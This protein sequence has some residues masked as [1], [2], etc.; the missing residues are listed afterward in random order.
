MFES[1]WERAVQCNR[2]TYKYCAL[3]MVVR[4]GINKK[5]TK[6]GFEAHEMET[7]ET[8]VSGS[9]RWQQT[10]QVWSARAHATMI[11]NTVSSYTREEKTLYKLI[12]LWYANARREGKLLQMNFDFFLQNELYWLTYRIF[13]CQ[14]ASIRPS[15]P[16]ALIHLRSC[17]QHR[18]TISDVSFHPW[19]E[20]RQ[21][22]RILSNLET[23]C[24]CAY[25]LFDLSD[26]GKGKHLVKEWFLRCH[27]KHRHME[28]ERRNLRELK[29]IEQK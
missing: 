7:D 16:P 19:R 2:M 3:G 12:D 17:Q 4:E 8:K 1:P 9:S 5:G 23:R 20:R 22:E 11:K 25:N 10:I 13:V 6:F 24:L 29:S 14:L 21:I 27:V 28:S 26:G 15:T 18:V